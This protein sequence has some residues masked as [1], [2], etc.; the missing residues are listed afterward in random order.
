M[1][2]VNT[3]RLHLLKTWAADTNKPPPAQ[4]PLQNCNTSDP[5]GVTPQEKRDVYD[6]GLTEHLL[7][8]F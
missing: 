4:E 6:T 1:R 7:T 3:T 8:L 5:F 2:H